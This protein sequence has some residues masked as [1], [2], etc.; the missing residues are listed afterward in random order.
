MR[1]CCDVVSAGTS[2]TRCCASNGSSIVDNQQFAVKVYSPQTL[3]K[4]LEQI[5]E[6][7]SNVPTN[8]LAFT[9]LNG[10]NTLQFNLQPQTLSMS[11]DMLFGADDNAISPKIQYSFNKVIWN[12]YTN[13]SLKI[14]Q[15]ETLFVR[16]DNYTFNSQTKQYGFSITPDIQNAKI[17]VDGNISSLLN[18]DAT[19]NDYIFSRLFENVNN[20]QSAP[21]LDIKAA[22]ETTYKDIFGNCKD[23]S[24]LELIVNSNPSKILKSLNLPD[25]SK[26]K[27]SLR[28]VCKDNIEDDT[29]FKKFNGWEYAYNDGKSDTD[30]ITEI[31]ITEEDYY[32]YD[33]FDDPLF[34]FS[35]NDNYYDEYI[36]DLLR[37]YYA[38]D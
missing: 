31:I 1:L 30:V 17:K 23:I 28:V 18:K 36:K 2:T 3:Q 6:N 32:V 4:T 26:N 24:H 34:G 9:S 11:K 8:S 21:T 14:N 20:M 5:I 16:G 13:E 38:E 19:P 27:G 29:V 12:E 35:Y 25:L 33:T 15:N 37:R 7:L 10:S 22:N